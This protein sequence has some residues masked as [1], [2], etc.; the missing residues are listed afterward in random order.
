MSQI[1]NLDISSA[2][3][4]AH[5]PTDRVIDF[6]L[7]NVS[8]GRRDF[9]EEAA[10]VRIAAP[11]IFYTLRNGGHWVVVGYEEFSEIAKDTETFNSTP[12][13]I[14]SESNEPRLIPL[15]LDPPIHTAYRAVLNKFFTPR[16]VMS[17]AD[18]IRSSAIHL[19]DAVVNQGHCD[20]VAS[21]AEVLPVSV[22]LK[23]L[24]LPLDRLPEYRH[25]AKVYLGSPDFGA[26]RQ[27]GN[28]IIGELSTEIKQRQN[29][30]GDDVISQ[31]LTADIDGRPPTFEEAINFCMMLFLAGLDSVTVSMTY[32][33]RHLA[34]DQRLQAWARAN[35]RKIPDLTEELLRRYGVAQPARTVTR[36]VEVGEVSMKKGDRVLLL[37]AAVNLDPAIFENPEVVD[38]ERPKAP[39]MAF[40]A[41]PHRCVGMHLA[42]VELQTAYEELLS[43]IPTFR[44]DPEGPQTISGGHVLAL[45]SLWLRWD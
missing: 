10:A 38:P 5:V 8:A 14:P 24:G 7:Y 33:V 29:E 19:I 22:F 9:M 4:P 1:G 16:S 44:V 23:L 21:F 20:F 40:N 15:H 37:A 25:A 12:Y 34:E 11:N 13:R 28:W 39:H 6:D 35:P 32:G 41:G 27:M 45:N 42:R 17:L 30:P 43:R 18:H 3:M 36:D 2:A 31:I 26:R